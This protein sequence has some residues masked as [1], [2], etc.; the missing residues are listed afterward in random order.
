MNYSKAIDA[1]EA[2]LLNIGRIDRLCQRYIELLDE[3]KSLI[4]GV[5]SPVL[6]S[7]GGG[8]RLS[9]DKFG[10]TIAR[11]Q[12]L[13]EDLNGYI[14]E[15]VDEKRKALELINRLPNLDER[16]ILIARYV[17]QE[18][19]AQICRSFDKSTYSAA[20]VVT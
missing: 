8:S 12:Q 17:N 18:T 7:V 2:Y 3:Q 1:A 15:L 5:G 19:V 14:D 9:P 11:I 4:A 20:P 13:E 10:D 16:T 6:D